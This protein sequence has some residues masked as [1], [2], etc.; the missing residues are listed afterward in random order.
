MIASLGMYDMPFVAAANDAIWASVAAR[1]DGA[2]ACL[3]RSRPARD[4]WVDPTLLL[5]HTCGWPLMTELASRV[6]LVATPVY[7]H[8]GCEGAQYRSWIL[9]RA[10]SPAATVSD[11]RGGRVAINGWDSN[12]GMNLLR[13]AVAPL[14]VAG[15][16]FGSVVVTGAHLASVAAVVA[17]DADAAAI[18]CVTYG[19]VARHRPELLAGTRILA[20]TPASAGLPLISGT[21][22][23]A[24]RIQEL[25]DALRNMLGDPAVEWARAALGWVGLAELTEADYRP[26]IE[27]ADAARRLGMDR[28]A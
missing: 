20:A 7:D 17:G 9:L 19:L 5:G 27:L 8:R 4:L 3:D 2:P 10:D 13:A 21:S 22:T 28:L 16:F 11:L 24:A 1:V 12:S 26:L 25:R 6:Q 15:R 14:G 23:P 18:D